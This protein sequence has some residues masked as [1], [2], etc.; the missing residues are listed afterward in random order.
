MLYRRGIYDFSPISTLLLLSTQKVGAEPGKIFNPAAC[1]TVAA[2][3]Q[4]Y[5][6]GIGLLSAKMY[7]PHF[8]SCKLVHGLPPKALEL[9][10]T[11]RFNLTAVE[12]NWEKA[13]DHYLVTEL[14]PHFVLNESTIS[15]LWRSNHPR[16]SPNF[17]PWLRDKI[18][19]W[20]GNEAKDLLLPVLQAKS[21]VSLHTLKCN[22]LRGNTFL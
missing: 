22:K 6:Q 1:T 8:M 18:W 13:W 9:Q 20:P 12:K 17:S 10:A 19:E 14:S 2:A 3:S 7:V 16:P 15:G 5:R 4:D 11:L 21:L